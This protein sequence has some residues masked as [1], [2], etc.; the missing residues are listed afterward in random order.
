MDIDTSMAE[1]S[2]ATPDITLSDDPFHYFD[3]TSDYAI[4]ISDPVPEAPAI[5]QWLS[6]NQSSQP[7]SR[8]TAGGLRRLHRR[9]VL[10]PTNV[11]LNTTQ[12]ADIPSNPTRSHTNGQLSVRD[13]PFSSA[14]GRL[15]TVAEHASHP[16]SPE[17]V[18]AFL[19]TLAPEV[20]LS[21]S[22]QHVHHVVETQ[23]QMDID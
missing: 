13:N 17:E 16:V 5:Q 10:S 7:E 22:N 11:N 14:L 6:S 20:M 23:D 19:K 1:S 8:P 12:Q 3:D 2:A 15:N 4:P 9:G 18:E 21:M